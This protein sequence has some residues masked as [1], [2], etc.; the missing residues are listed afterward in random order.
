[1]MS[2]L[3]ACST[4]QPVAAVHQLAGPGLQ[5][6][7]T[8]PEALPA[9][10]NVSSLR[11]LSLTE[12]SGRVLDVRALQHL[13]HLHTLEITGSESEHKAPHVHMLARLTQLRSLSLREASSLCAM[14][15]KGLTHLALFGG[16]LHSAPVLPPAVLQRYAGQLSSLEVDWWNR[17]EAPSFLS[18]LPCLQQ[19]LHTLKIAHAGYVNTTWQPSFGQ[20]QV[21]DISLWSSGPAD[22]QCFWDLSQLTLAELRISVTVIDSSRA[23]MD[24]LPIRRVRTASLSAS[25]DIHHSVDWKEAR[26]P[27]HCGDWEIAVAH[28]KE[29]KG[30]FW[31]FPYPSLYVTDFIGALVMARA[32]PRLHVNGQPSRCL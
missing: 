12:F 6:L 9:I 2:C 26:C 27:A 10:C 21:L 7:R 19:K 15:P 18:A 8:A 29:D 30:G 17:N 13:P 4:N 28:V 1:M 20:L 22:K 11:E 25:F 31:P 23:L 16:D 5:K 24:L 14:L 32:C 3:C